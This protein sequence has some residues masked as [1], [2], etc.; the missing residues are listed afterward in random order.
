MVTSSSPPTVHTRAPAAAHSS[1]V[2]DSNLDLLRAAAIVMVVAYHLIQTS[3]VRPPA[4]VRFWRAGEYGVDLFFVLSGWLIGS[5][6]WKE[7]I[8]FG[9]VQLWQFWLRRW[10]RT[11]PPYFAA[12]T[13]AWVAVHFYRDQGFNWH[14]LF[15]LQNY[16]PR[17]EFF[18]ISWSLCIEEHFYLL[19]PL[20]LAFAGRKSWR[21]AALFSILILCAPVARWLRSP[22]STLPRFGYGQTATHLRTE[23][24]ILGFWAAY[25]STCLPA[26]WT[27]LRAAAP[28]TLLASAIVLGATRRSALKGI[29]PAQL[30]RGI[31]D[32][33]VA[34]VCDHILRANRRILQPVDAE[35]STTVHR[36]ILPRFSGPRC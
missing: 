27:A 14:Y 3:P 17:L 16:Q 25:C 36:G 26:R 7:H 29:F 32:S 23:G 8:R 2:R 10:C 24:L 33:L 12:L 20:L 4:H 30:V 35:V 1:V 31:F 15:F 18:S 28:W 6:Y 19:V 13:L 11:L 9:S 21:V 34:W 22:H 5:L